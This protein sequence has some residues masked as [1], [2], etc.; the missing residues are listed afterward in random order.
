MFKGKLT[1]FVSIVVLGSLGGCATGL[2]PQQENAYHVYESRG[3]LQQVKSTGT[4]VALGFLP[5]G[6]SFYGKEYGYGVL[7]L[8]LWPLSIAWDPISGYNAAESAN[9]YATKAHVEHQKQQE[10]AALDDQ[11]ALQQIDNTRYVAKKHTIEAKY[12]VN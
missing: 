1:T 9:Y 10:I 7:N 11:L 12:D 8:L 3:Q 4:G 5:G 6:G 2:N